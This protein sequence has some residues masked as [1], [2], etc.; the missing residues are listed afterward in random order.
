VLRR[1]VSPQVMGGVQAAVREGRDSIA[2]EERVFT[3]LFADLVAF[4]ALAEKSSLRDVVDLLNL[5]IGANSSTILHWGGYIDKI[6]G[7]SIFA[8]FEEP[9]NSVIA[10]VEIQKQFNI[11]NFFRIKDEQQPIELRIGI[12]TG[13]CLIASIGSAEFLELTY[14][15]DAVNTASRIEKAALPGSILV[16]DQ[17]I[18]LVRSNVTLGDGVSL[19]VKGKSHI[20]VA[21]Y[22]KRVS[23]ERS[24]GKVLALGIDDDI[25]Q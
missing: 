12:H 9:L 10:A 18:E 8:V 1:Y 17:T 3:F 21:H 7:D 2:D 15:G 4:T 19:S 20:L 5:S 14:I 24:P 11:L 22:V 16:S 23:F 25:F 6:M 13:P